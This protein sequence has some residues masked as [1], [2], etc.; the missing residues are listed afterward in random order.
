MVIH[1]RRP[2]EEE[3]FCLNVDGTAAKEY[4]KGINEPEISIEDFRK[5]KT[6]KFR[7]K[8]NYGQGK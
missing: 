7:K 2:G 8:I 4:Q 3:T 6:E 5:E 1:V